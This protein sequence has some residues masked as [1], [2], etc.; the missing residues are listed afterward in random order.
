MTIPEPEMAV[1]T[2][3]AQTCGRATAFLEL[4]DRCGTDRQV[5]RPGRQAC[6][7]ARRD[8]G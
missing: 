3:T 8:T 1:A 7:A 5:R 4:I 6:E 2:R